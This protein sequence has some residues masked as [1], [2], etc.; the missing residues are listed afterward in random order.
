MPAL[1]V[2]DLHCH[3]TASDG[4]F[5]P[6]EV[7]RAAAEA[8]VTAIALTD[9]DTIAGVAEARAEAQR[10]GVDFLP[11]MEVTAAHPRPGTMHLLAYGFD[12]KHRE[13]RKLCRILADAR[14]ERAEA[15]LHRLR[16]L[17]VEMSMD[18]VI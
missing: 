5:T 4:T 1:P 13:I 7:V 18:D 14:E 16:F 17:G 12:T 9:H 6:A 8:G 10:L 11:G 2:V 3:S 15:I